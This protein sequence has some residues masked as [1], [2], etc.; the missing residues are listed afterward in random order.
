MNLATLT[1]YLT[2]TQPSV[3]AILPLRGKILNVEKSEE[4]HIYKNAQVSDMI[5]A[6]GLGLRG[7]DFDAAKLRYG[8]IIILTDADVDGAHIRTL[9]LT[10]LFRYQVRECVRVVG[11]LSTL[12]SLTHYARASHQ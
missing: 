5:V 7:E 12:Y 3:Q 2:P 11:G 6:L 10:F 8:K 9:L 4:S 1:L